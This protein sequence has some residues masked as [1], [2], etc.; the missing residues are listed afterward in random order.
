MSPCSHNLVCNHWLLTEHILCIVGLLK[1]VKP[2]PFPFGFE[3]EMCQSSDPRPPILWVE[4]R[5]WIHCCVRSFCRNKIFFLKKRELEDEG[6]MRGGRWIY[7]RQVAA[8]FELWIMYCSSVRRKWEV[9]F[10]LTSY[11][12][13]IHLN[14]SVPVCLCRPEI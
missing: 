2:L 12:S 11:C 9:E 13:H 8:A 4:W 10:T 6:R 3:E 1:N 14:L 7:H 5:W